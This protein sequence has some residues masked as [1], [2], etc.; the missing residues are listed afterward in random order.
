MKYYSS[1][2]VFEGEGA[3]R[4]LHAPIYGKRIAVLYEKFLKSD[5]I[6]A[7]IEAV[8]S[9]S[10]VFDSCALRDSLGEK[11]LPRVVSM[12]EQFDLPSFWAQA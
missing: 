7:S 9:S 6:R 8:P 1:R 12:I 11:D 10:T 3:I 2:Q 4:G 5:R